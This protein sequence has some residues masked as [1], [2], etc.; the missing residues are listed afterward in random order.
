MAHLPGYTYT[1]YTWK[2]SMLIHR[3]SRHFTWTVPWCQQG[4]NLNII[5]A[6]V[7]W[8]L[9]II[10]KHVSGGQVTSLYTKSS[11][12]WCPLS[13]RRCNLVFYREYYIHADSQMR[14][15]RPGIIHS[16]T[17]ISW[18]PFMCQTLLHLKG[19]P[20]G[21]GSDWGIQGRS[22]ATRRSCC[23]NRDKS[24]IPDQSD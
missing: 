16:I 3:E 10:G 2:Y 6:Q 9:C 24:Q 4:E 1:E 15:L 19:L 14:N 17:G 13:F 23:I 21:W 11:R 8:A 20:C 22:H 7:R 12:H 18:A 5:L